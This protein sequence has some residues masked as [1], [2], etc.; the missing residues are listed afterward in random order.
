MCGCYIIPHISISLSKSSAPGTSA[1]EQNALANLTAMFDNTDDYIYF[2]NRAHEFTGASQTLVN[3]THD[4]ESWQDLIGKTDYEVFSAEY[5][6]IYY[7][8]EKKLFNQGMAMTR[9]TQPVLDRNG[10][11]GWVDNRKYAIYDKFGDVVGLFGVARDITEIKLT[12]AALRKSEERIRL[13]MI[14]AKQAWFDLEVATG[15]VE[16]SD[17]YSKML[18]YSPEEFH[19]SLK[20]WQANLHPE[21]AAAVMAALQRCMQGNEPVSIEYRRKTKD[22][23]WIWLFAVAKV[24]DWRVNHEPLRMIGIHM[25]I[26]ERKKLEEELRQKAYVDYLTEVNNRGHFMELAEKELARTLRYAKPLA[27]FMI[28]I[29]WFKRI[30]DSHGHKLGDAV[31]K[32]MAD[33][34][35]T[36]LREVDIIGRIGGEEF[37]V[38]LPETDIQEAVEAA[39]R[40]RSA[41]AATEVPLKDGLPVK[42]TVSIGVASVVSIDDNMDVLLNRA[43][44]AL[45]RAKESGR[46]QVCVAAH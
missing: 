9:E 3:I 29:D 8:L 36:T 20:E 26:S 15:E 18:G 44:E 24:I 6:D 25:D 42:F 34:F 23:G 43:D 2:K 30:N 32:K 22:G 19:S 28:D 13:A 17:E 27:I 5:A 40:L 37:A 14:A 1:L 10:K 21:D 16:V 38:L 33:T 12:E 41:V 46:N 4:A 35:R 31:L 11:A 7:A 39:E 45:Y